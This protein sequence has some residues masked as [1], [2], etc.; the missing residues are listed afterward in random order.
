MATAAGERRAVLLR[1]EDNVAVAVRPIPKGAIVEV[2]GR[3]VEAREPIGPG[4]KLALVDIGAGEPVRKYGQVIGF[5]SRAIPAGSW[6]HVQNVEADRFERAYAF[7]T[8][9]PPVPPRVEPRTFPGFLRPDGRVG[10]R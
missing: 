3:A 10:T 6:V 8:E 2:G 9:R 5:A 1:G 4:H 7:A